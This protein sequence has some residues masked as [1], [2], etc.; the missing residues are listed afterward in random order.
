M[1]PLAVLHVIGGGDTGG[2]MSHLLPLLSALVRAGCRVHLL[3]LGE[4]GLADAARRRGLPVA[5]LPM[6]GARDPR[7]LRP[8][9]RVLAGGSGVFEA[10][11]SEAPVPGG[12]GASAATV[13]GRED[14]T[15]RAPARWDVVHTH[16]M[17]ANLPLRLVA[18]GLRHRPCLFT[19][20]HSDLGL[21]YESPQV[22]RV[23]QGIDRLT[24]AAVDT[25]VCVSDSLRALLVERGY[26]AA[27]LL[28]IHSGLEDGT[29]PGARTDPAD[30]TEGATRAAPHARVFPFMRPDR[31]VE[32]TCSPTPPPGG[33]EA[34]A[35]TQREPLPAGEQWAPAQVEIAAAVPRPCARVGTVARLVAVKDLDLL[36]E[37]AGLLRRTHPE[38]EVVI[39]GDGP[40]RARLEAHAAEAGLA[41]TVRFTGRLQDAGPALREMDVYM[42]TSVFEGGVSMSALEAMRSGLPVVTTAAGGV[43]EV[44]IDGETGFV[45]TRETERGALAAALAERAAALLDDP[46]LRVRMGAAGA[47]RVR[48]HF[49]IG[50]TA[51]RTLRAY[52]RSLAA[53]G[54]RF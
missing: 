30:G 18:Q 22:A 33:Q 46:A 50:L 47:N 52:E 6:S 36:L 31:V 21:D 1:R 8:L 45:V 26:P 49:T 51:A 5:V 14:S 19:T 13:A 23:Y 41:Q 35:P 42:V 29:S 4:G 32:P 3:C 7:V 48:A 17:R 34:P 27:K 28:T 11:G 39:V 40:E 2:A 12:T 20:V 53:R 43:T 38:V 25:I 54:G 15:G 24:A 10:L 9:R 16:G 44:V 37:V